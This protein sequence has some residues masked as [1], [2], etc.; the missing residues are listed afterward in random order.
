MNMRARRAGGSRLRKQ[1]RRLEP[2]LRAPIRAEMEHAGKTLADAIDALA[3]KDTGEMAEA[4]MYKVSSDG[5]GVSAGYS[6]KQ[7]G[8]KR[9]WKK[10]GF[11]SLWQEFG[12]KKHAAKPF[13]RPAYKAKL[14][15]ILDRIDRAVRDVIKGL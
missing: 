15:G 13:I 14:G 11:K 9:Q 2:E 12:T 10:G 7:T 6:A 3:P 4:A 5:L 1:L 8:F